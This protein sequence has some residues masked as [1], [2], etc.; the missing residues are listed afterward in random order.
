MVVVVRSQHAQPLARNRACRPLLP[1][2]PVPF[3]RNRSDHKP[4][5]ILHHHLHRYP[6]PTL[7]CSALLQ[8]TLDPVILAS[9]PRLDALI[10]RQSVSSASIIRSELMLEP[11]SPTLNARNGR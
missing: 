1:P 2:S 3:A 11:R 10:S 4:Y 8:S 5:I 7:R 6:N 9:L